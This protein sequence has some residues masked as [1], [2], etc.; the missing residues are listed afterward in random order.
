MNQKT[1]TLIHRN[2]IHTCVN[3]CIHGCDWKLR[4]LVLPVWQ[5]DSR[6]SCD[7]LSVKKNQRVGEAWRKKSHYNG[8]FR[9]LIE[10]A[11]DYITFTHQHIPSVRAHMR[12]MHNLC[13]HLNREYNYAIRAYV[14]E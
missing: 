2:D 11:K 8:S 9:V 5:S 13:M 4:R 10:D 12:L 14:T 1:S 7:L 3:R 6:I